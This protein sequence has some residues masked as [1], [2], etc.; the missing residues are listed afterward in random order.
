MD[1]DKIRLEQ[2]LVEL[3]AAIKCDT[4]TAGEWIK[5]LYEI[6]GNADRFLVEMRSR[7]TPLPSAQPITEVKAQLGV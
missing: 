7:P 2:L 6:T 5:K 3:I 4:G 1:Q